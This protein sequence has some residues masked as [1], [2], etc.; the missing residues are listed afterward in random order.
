MTDRERAAWAE[1]AMHLRT[2]SGGFGA[3]ARQ[4]RENATRVEQ[5]HPEEARIRRE[6]AEH[7]EAQAKVAAELAATAKRKA[8]EQ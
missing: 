8:E 5:R 7:H 1:L 3:I 2:R 6:S 4:E